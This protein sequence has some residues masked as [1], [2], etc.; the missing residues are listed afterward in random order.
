MNI[1]FLE[2]TLKSSLT[3]Q[4][5]LFH[6]FMFIRGKV[7]RN[8]K[9]RKTV[10]FEINKNAYFI[11]KHFQSSIAEILK[12]LLTFKKPII[13]IQNEYKAINLLEK[14]N[15]PTM[16][17]AGYGL[18]GIPPLWLKSFIIT[19]ELK[20]IIELRDIAIECEKERPNFYFKKNLIEIIAG[21]ARK[22]HLANMAHRDFYLAHFQLDKTFNPKNPKL[23]LIDLHRAIIK[24]SLARRW[25]IK[26]ISSLYFSA[27]KA[28]LTRTDICRFLKLYFNQ[29]LRDI[30]HQKTNFLHKVEK[31]ARKLY[32]TKEA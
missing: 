19:K 27:M 17:I 15:V 29:P 2:K 3:V 6:Y 12:N 32:A 26:D 28:G 24:K 14:I 16:K 5:D 20:N 10:R 22:M 31:R 13:S 18:K 30:F 21:I 25:K 11:K 4:K 23:Y 1:L 9:N 7:F 8:V